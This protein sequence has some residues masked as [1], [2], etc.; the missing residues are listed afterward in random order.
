MN[1]YEKLADALAADGIRCYQQS[2]DQLVVSQQTGPVSPNR[3][4]SFWLT[5]AAGSWHLF[6]WTPVGYSVPEVTDI[7]SLCRACMAHGSS[8]MYRVPADIVQR[9]GLH[10]LTGDEADLVFSKLVKPS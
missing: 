10:E 8:A 2:P 4:N 9:F 5:R 3:G 7:E 6:T 1:E